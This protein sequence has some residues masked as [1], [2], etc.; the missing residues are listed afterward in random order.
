MGFWVKNF[1]KYRLRY[2]IFVVYLHRERYKTL[3]IMNTQNSIQI[4]QAYATGLSAQSRQHKVQSQVFAAMG[5]S[6]LAE[7]Y[8]AHSSE[9]AEWVDKFTA[10]ILNLG[11][12]AKVEAAPAQTIY[13]DV[14][15]F[16]KAD[17]AVSEKEVPV[18]GQVTLSL[19]E[20]LTTFDLM[21]GYYQDE[22]EDMY[23]M[24]EQLELIGRIGLQNWLVK[25]L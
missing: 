15:E 11:G 18:L 5:L 13:K 14:V 6:K 9:E 25:Q 1:L 8:A 23:W 4:L 21:K 24:Q 16:L 20:D 22:E 7:K 19:A 12:E 10:R 3:D 17:L 2:K